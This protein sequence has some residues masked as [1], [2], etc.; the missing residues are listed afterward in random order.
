MLTKTITENIPDAVAARDLRGIDEAI[1]SLTAK[2]AAL[3]ALASSQSVDLPAVVVA[4]K[5]QEAAE[6]A[7]A[8][9]ALAAQLDAQ[10]DK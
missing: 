6:A 3:L 2:R 10:A 5:A 4:Q 7:E 9:A 1:A 8:G